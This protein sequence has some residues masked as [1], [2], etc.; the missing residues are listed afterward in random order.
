MSG[1][2]EGLRCA[3]SPAALC[4]IAERTSDEKQLVL[5]AFDPMNGRGRELGRFGINP[6]TAYMW[7]LSPD[8]TQIALAHSGKGAIHVLAFAGRAPLEIT[9][10]SWNS[11]ETLNWAADGKGLFAASRTEE[12]AVRLYIDL[13]GNMHTVWE[14]QGT[15]GNESAGSLGIPSPDGRHLAM[16]NFTHNANMWAMEDF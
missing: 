7:D 16:M 4:A 10:T 5:T 9:P 2:I 12:S 6:D 15:L 11:L 8:G 1:R 14:K 13:K 3:K